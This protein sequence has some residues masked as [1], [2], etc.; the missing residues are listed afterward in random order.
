MN[1]QGMIK[2]KTTKKNKGGRPL[3]DG[4]NKK[5]VIQKLEAVWA[6]GGSDAEAAYYADIS[7]SALSDYLKKHPK[8]SGRKAALLNKPILKAR[9]TVVGGLD[10][11][12]NAKWYLSRKKKGEFSTRKEL[13]HSG[14]T[15]NKFEITMTTVNAKNK[16]GKNKKAGKSVASAKR[17][18]N[19]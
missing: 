7:T 10:D 11:P 16:V 18:N 8:V 4:K 15:E 1:W 12:D 2:K 5:A 19:K 6:V 17:Q 9:M 3:F 14:G 13:E